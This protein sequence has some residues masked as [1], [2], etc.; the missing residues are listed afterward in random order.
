MGITTVV[1]SVRTWRDTTAG[2][3]PRVTAA[4]QADAKRLA[5][6]AHV[7]PH[8]PPRPAAARDRAGLTARRAWLRQGGAVSDKVKSLRKAAEKL[9]SRSDALLAIVEELRA[10]S[11]KAEKADAAA[12]RKRDKKV[13]DT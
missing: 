12:R 2:L 9:A 1:D 10:L 11:A 13:R 3:L 5:H 4:A 7:R 8:S 6:T